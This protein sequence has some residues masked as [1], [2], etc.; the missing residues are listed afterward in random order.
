MLMEATC[1]WESFLPKQA[2]APE[3][4]DS[5]SQ[6]EALGISTRKSRRGAGPQVRYWYWC[7]TGTM[8]RDRDRVWWPIQ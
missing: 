5:D 7:C 6:D 4:S 2:A 3:L 1:S 8:D